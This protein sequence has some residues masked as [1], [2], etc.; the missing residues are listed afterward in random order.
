MAPA[1]I[2]LVEDENIVAL[3]IQDL[4]QILG[5]DIVGVVSSGE[6]AIARAS[7]TRPDLALMDIRLK[8]SIDGIEAAE[9]IRA[10]LDIPVVYLTAYADEATMQRAKLTQPFGYLIKPFEQRELHTAVEIALYKHWMEQR[11]KESE[12][13]LATT[14]RSVGDAVIATD[15]LGAI[16]FINPTAETLTAWSQVD[17]LGKQASAVLRFI[18]GQTGSLLD[19][20]LQ[21]ALWNGVAHGPGGDVLLAARDG[22]QIPIDYNA[23]P[24]QDDKGQI[25]GVVLV[26]R[27]VTERKRSERE[28]ARRLAQTQTLREVMQAAAS[29]LDF[30]QVLER[31]CQVL[32]TKMQV[33]FLGFAFADESGELGLHP[34]QIGYTSSHRMTQVA[35]SNSVCGRV[36][37]AGEPL[38]IGDVRR[39]PLYVEGHPE[40]RSELAIPVRVEERVIGVLNLESRRLHA[41][42]DEDLAFY[43]AIASQLG[44][45]LEN[46]RLYRDVQR[47]ARDLEDALG[48]LRELDR[49]KSEFMQNASHELRTPLTMILGYVELL[50]DGQMGALELEQQTVLE[51]VKRQAQLLDDLVQDI[52]LS[53]AAQTSLLKPAP[54]AM[55]DLI[56][57]RV[58]DFSLQVTQAGLTLR[59]EVEPGMPPVVGVLF[60]LQRVFDNLMS[61]ALKFT[62]SGGMIAVSLRRENDQCL[63]EVADTG[64]GIAPDQQKRIF[65]RFYQIDGSTRRQYG[66][67]GLGLALV[68][69][70]VG[71]HG[72]VVDVESRVGEG[73]TFTVRLPFESMAK[74][75]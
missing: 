60:Y 17:A 34:A 58:A 10:H 38:V 25:A 74:G 57:A 44:V 45:A 32:Q 43:T 21:S 12:R 48:K 69:E 20:P 4:L 28:I 47:H 61:N 39:E 63:L 27:D 56:A 40:I 19:S 2:L 35:L 1:R 51:I 5:H 67:L 49:L 3:E 66:G 15:E 11:L 8:G 41:F 59:L 70:I 22:R 31:T 71:V 37:Q 13:W 62:P 46:A 53:L 73:S 16:V 30:D 68:K 54:I 29:T 14:L 75:C 24:L 55:D 42:D 72:G 36:L 26:F 9:R 65:D 33:E 23:A 18:D 6:E 7:E 52:T 50:T 64:I